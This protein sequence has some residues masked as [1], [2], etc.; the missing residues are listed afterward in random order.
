VPITEVAEV[1]VVVGPEGGLTESE[2]A[3]LAGAG[4]VPVRL[5]QEVLRTSTAGLAAVAALLAGTPRW[6]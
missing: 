1:V 2:V 6:Q 4:A 3:T 5:G